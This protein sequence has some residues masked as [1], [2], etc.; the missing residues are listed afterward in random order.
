MSSQIK[1]GLDLSEVM[2]EQVRNYWIKPCP[3]SGQKALWWHGNVFPWSL[4]TSTIPFVGM[5]E[6]AILTQA[7]EAPREIG[8]A[9]AATSIQVLTFI[10]IYKE[11]EIKLCWEEGISWPAAN[12][13]QQQ[14]CNCA[15]GNQHHMELKAVPSSQFS[16]LHPAL[17]TQV[18]LACPSMQSLY[19]SLWH[20]RGLHWFEISVGWK[21]WK[22]FVI[23]GYFSL[24]IT[25]VFFLLFFTGTCHEIGKVLMNNMKHPHNNLATHSISKNF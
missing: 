10:Y 24:R 12:T 4:P 5:H 13:I 14:K 1:P 18:Y 7:T 6:V 9:L 11:K 16:P 19:P 2:Q 15:S 22:I 8:T 17:Q 20:G 25:L 3:L 21:T 23:W